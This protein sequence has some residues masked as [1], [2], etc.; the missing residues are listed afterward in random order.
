MGNPF[1][2][3]AAASQLER[4]LESCATEE[5]AK[6]W[7][8]A[9]EELL[10]ELSRGAELPEGEERSARLALLL[11]AAPFFSLRGRWKDYL[12]LVGPYLA[13]PTKQLLDDV[14]EA[15]T[16][17]ILQHGQWGTIG[18]AMD[19]LEAAAA[20]RDDDHF[21][22]AYAKTLSSTVNALYSL[23]RLSTAESFLARFERV[24]KRFAQV[25]SLY[26][27]LAYGEAI[28]AHL[29]DGELER[30]RRLLE[31]Q[32]ALLKA[33]PSTPLRDAR[34]STLTEV[35]PHLLAA[36]KVDDCTEIGEDLWQLARRFPKEHRLAVHWVTWLQATLP[37]YLSRDDAAPFLARFGELA[38]RCRGDEALGNRMA[39]LVDA[40]WD[41]ATTPTSRPL[42]PLLMDV[43]R[44]FGS[45]AAARER[46]DGLRVRAGLPPAGTGCLVLVLLAAAGLGAAAL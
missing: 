24:P 37:T 2:M 10:T 36:R 6:E 18:D 26:H 22:V 3:A 23:G 20:S 45:V 25:T 15:L 40:L 27:A 41:G 1:D 44:N 7:L 11:R 9:L 13:R 4:L 34:A 16:D 14:F 8:P 28:R 32:G 46:T 43:E 5:G 30:A 12:R 39:A 33:H 21:W 29:A 38:R 35:L 19:V 17:P 42:A 31:D